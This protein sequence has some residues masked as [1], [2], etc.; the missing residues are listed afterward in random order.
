MKLK[1]F[2]LALT[3]LSSIS[4]QA[5]ADN[6]NTKTEGLTVYSDNWFEE[7]ITDGK[8]GLELRYRFQSLDN[9]AFDDI[10]R[11][12]TIRALLKYQTK[13]VDGVSFLGEIRTVQ[14]VG[15]TDLFNDTLNGVTTRPVIPD[16]DSLEIDQ[17]HIKLEDIVPDTDITI[18]RRKFSLSNQR[19]ISELPF[20]QNLNSF[21]G[22]VIEN[23]SLP[24]T[25]LHYSYSNNFNRTFTDDSVVGNFD[26]ANFHLV[27]GEHQLNDNHKLIGYG[28]LLGIKEGSFA[29]AS[30]LATNTFGANAKGKLNIAEKTWFHYDVEYAHQT[31]NSENSRNFDLGYYRIQPSISYDAILFTVGYEVLEGD[32]STGFSTPLA[33]LH[34]FNGFA[35][36]F[37]NTPADGL[38][39]AYAKITYTIK[40]SDVYIAGYDI[41]GDT[42]LHLAYHDFGAEN[43]NASYGTEWDIA[44]KKQLTDNAKFLFEYANYRADNPLSTSNVDIDREGFYAELSINF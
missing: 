16:P 12:S 4:Y 40:E 8:V 14:R 38:E 28:Y 15:S 37:G 31:D 13:P 9:E 23:K 22:I 43:T 25:K 6:L 32:G 30:N 7:A 2:T 39:D 42:K 19:F 41:F 26:D 11:A 24:D 29:G 36:V 35:D 20:R 5:T 1:Y 21:D 33:L 3:L 18:G 10:G 34:A 27:H 17:L 44:I